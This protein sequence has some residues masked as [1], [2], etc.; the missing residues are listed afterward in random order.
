MFVFMD[1]PNSLIL[2]A[3][4]FEVSWIQDR[5]SL[6]EELDTLVLLVAELT[7]I[8]LLRGNGSVTSGPCK[9]QLVSI[10]QLDVVNEDIDAFHEIFKED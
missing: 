7:M 2:L 6:Q 5:E 8:L 1:L 9:V 4:F 10:F 3:S